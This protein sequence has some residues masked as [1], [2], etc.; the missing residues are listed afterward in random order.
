[1]PGVFSLEAKAGKQQAQGFV[2]NQLSWRQLSWGPKTPLEDYSAALC[3]LLQ[4]V[5][6]HWQV[7]SRGEMHR[8]YRLSLALSNQYDIVCWAD[9]MQDNKFTWFT[10]GH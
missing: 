4:R 2:L 9:S 6:K 7:R 3:E 5:C 10:T 1:M 8:L